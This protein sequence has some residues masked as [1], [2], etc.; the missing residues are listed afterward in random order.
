MGSLRGQE[1]AA[2]AKAG[3]QFLGFPSHP[4]YR[5]TSIRG[6]KGAM[7]LARSVVMARGKMKEI[8]PDAVFSTGGYASAPIVNSARHFHIPYVLHEQNVVPGRTNRILGRSAECICTVFRNGSQYFEGVDVVR[9]GMPIRP[10]FRADQQSILGVAQAIK[11][12]SPMVLVM[13]GSQ[14]AQALNEAACATAV[15]VVDGSLQWLHITGA[16][17]FEAMTETLK[18]LAITSKYELRAFLDADEM[19]SAMFRASLAVCRSGAG[20]LA[21]LAA[22]R[23]P[24]ILVPYPQAFRNHQHLNAQEF[25]DMGAAEI[26]PESKLQPAQLESKVK[27]WLDDQTR[28]NL[29][30]KA[31]QEWDCPNAVSAIADRVEVAANRGAQE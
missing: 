28:Q 20:T 7:N 30:A 18:K 8:H 19:A 3:V 31:L 21:E 27:S 1:S 2:C 5:L 4:L 24:A 14:G 26:M 11:D 12:K 17:H 16:K 13:G 9:T 22:M 25:V 10:E 15:R 6:M 29:A 23:K